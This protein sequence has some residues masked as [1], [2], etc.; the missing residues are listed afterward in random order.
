MN[1]LDLS[2]FK[3]FNKT[4]EEMQEIINCEN[5]GKSEQYIY[6][7]DQKK[8]PYEYDVIDVIERL[9][10]GNEDKIKYLE[11]GVNEGYTFDKVQASVKHGVD[12]YG[13][14]KNITH[15]MSSQEFFTYNKHFWKN[16][17]DIIFI[18]GLHISDIIL[19]EVYESLKILNPGGY[20]LLHDIAPSKESS[21]EVWYGDYK[22][23]IENRV[24]MTNG[25]K[26]FS[27]YSNENPWV[28][29]N[30]DSWKALAYLRTNTNLTVTSVAT[31]CCGIVS[32]SIKD[33]GFAKPPKPSDGLYTWEFYKKNLNEILNPVSI[34]DLEQFSK[35]LCKKEEV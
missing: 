19:Q 3:T 33:F 34:G 32:K 9:I 2:I 13:G 29:F 11:I 22:R 14:C 21:Q 23:F 31:A 27:E 6:S 15:R 30:G 8:I 20:I 24:Q 5:N 17:Y 4:T 18:D 35:T 26:S 1:E 25:D 12:P 10:T 16:T 28:G 7:N